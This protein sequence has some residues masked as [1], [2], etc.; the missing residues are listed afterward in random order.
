MTS[1]VFSAQFHSTNRLGEPEATSG[2]QLPGYSPTITLKSLDQMPKLKQQYHPDLYLVQ[3]SAF[4]HPGYSLEDMKKVSESVDVCE[5][6]TDKIAYH[7]L[8]TLRR[9]FDIFTGYR[10]PPKGEENNPAHR[11]DPHN[12]LLRLVMLESVAAIPG[13]AGSFIRHLKS[14]RKLRREQ[15]WVETLVE[16]AQNERMHL[17]IYL[18]GFQDVVC[19]PTLPLKFFIYSSQF[20]FTWIYCAAYMFNPTLCHRFVGY[21][22]NSAV[23]TYKRFIVDAEKGFYPEFDIP[24]PNIAKAYWKMDENATLADTLYYACADECKHREV[25]H[26]FANINA[27]DPNPYLLPSEPYGDAPHPS[28]SLQS[29][30]HHPNG[31][32]REEI[33]L[34][35]N[36]FQ[37]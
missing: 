9:V 36:L 37:I 8:H 14:V 11:I 27:D 34:A 31:W 4:S 6:T 19:A 21:L 30:I 17:L 1:S 25:N 20:I 10:N 2:D 24:A 28:K 12:V 26:T 33:K 7:G 13:Y 18:Q 23:H 29:N 22:E 16:E 32:K 15:L 35:P 5:N 3:N